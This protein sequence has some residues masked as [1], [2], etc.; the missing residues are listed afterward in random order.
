MKIKFTS[1]AIYPSSIFQKTCYNKGKISEQS[2]SRCRLIQNEKKV[3]RFFSLKAR[4]RT[5]AL[6]NDTVTDFVIK[7]IKPTIENNNRK[8]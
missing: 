6:L 5:K 7:K 2:P 3:K 4:F 8:S 1:T